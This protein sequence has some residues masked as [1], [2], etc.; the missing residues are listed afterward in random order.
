MAAAVLNAVDALPHSPL[1]NGCSSMLRQVCFDKVWAGEHVGASRTSFIA[2]LTSFM[3]S[4]PVCVRDNALVPYNGPETPYKGPE[5]PSASVISARLPP[6]RP[7]GPLLR[8]LVPCKGPEAA[9]S[10]SQ[11]RN[12]AITMPQRHKSPQRPIHTIRTSAPDITRFRGREQADGR[13]G[14]YRWTRRY[15][16][17]DM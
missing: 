14:T 7:S 13:V 2:I 11:S 5:G 12:V 17:L 10:R 8:A 6:S 9:T 3:E 16:A 1:G 15:V 4:Q